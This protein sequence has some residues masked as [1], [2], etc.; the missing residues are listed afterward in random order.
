MFINTWDNTNTYSGI[1]TNTAGA[2]GSPYDAAQN[3]LY[4]LPNSLTNSDASFNSIAAINTAFNPV[5]DSTYMSAFSSSMPMMNGMQNFF[6]P[7]GM[8]SP[9]DNSLNPLQNSLNPFQKQEDESEISEEDAEYEE[10]EDGEEIDEDGEE[11]EE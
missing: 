2:L 9:F 6:S 8:Q 4:M 5:Q 1:F 7:F 11:I 10:S 3:P